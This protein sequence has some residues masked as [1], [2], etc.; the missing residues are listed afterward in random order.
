MAWNAGNL[1]RLI[2]IQQLWMEVSNEPNPQSIWL[3]KL[4]LKPAAAVG[5]VKCSPG[6]R[7]KLHL[8]LT[9]FRAPPD[10]L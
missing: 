10:Y 7:M 2:T 8:R 3:Q 1:P 5:D 4:E 9:D 6:L